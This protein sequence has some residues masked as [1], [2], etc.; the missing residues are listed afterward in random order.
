METYRSESI[1]T[2][3][4][5]E[6][7]RPFIVD[8]FLRAMQ[9]SLTV[10]RGAWNEREERERF[11][12]ALDVG[13]TTIVQ[14]DGVDVG[15][16]VLVELPDV[17]LVHTIAIAPEHQGHGIGTE[18]IRDVVNLGRQTNRHVVLSVLK[19]N[20]GAEALYRRLG[21]EIRESHGDYHHMQFAG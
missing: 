3:P 5:V 16:V 12:R 17:L 14:A 19:V 2:R 20:A 13:R 4:A 6:S 8:C 7:D 11:E 18:V 10:R 15:F 1:A 9:P 21:F